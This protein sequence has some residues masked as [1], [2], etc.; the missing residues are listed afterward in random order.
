MM[1]DPTR[2]P[3]S[4]AGVPANLVASIVRAISCQHHLTSHL[5]VQPNRRNVFKE[6]AVRDEATC[7]AQHPGSPRP[8]SSYVSDA[9]LITLPIESG[10]MC[11]Y[12]LP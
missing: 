8:C 9:L 10:H 1:Q 7:P 12:W 5:L 2:H 11:D 3:S 6:A 4:V